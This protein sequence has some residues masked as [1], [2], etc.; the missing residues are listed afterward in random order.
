MVNNKKQQ[1]PCPISG[2]ESDRLL[3]LY[4]GE[5]APPSWAAPE[6]IAIERDYLFSADDLAGAGGVI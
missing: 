6:P 4:L 2:T 3:I 1:R 5:T